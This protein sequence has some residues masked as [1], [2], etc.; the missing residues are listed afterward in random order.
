MNNM[1]VICHSARIGADFHAELKITA[2]SKF[3]IKITFGENEFIGFGVDLIDALRQLRLNFLEPLEISIL[4]N[5]CRRDFVSSRMQRQST[6]GKVG[7][8]LCMGKAS[9]KEDVVLTFDPAP[10]EAV[11]LVAEQDIHYKN[12]LEGLGK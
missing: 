4:L 10:F 7:Y 3:S 9:Q 8:I 6:G 2:D 12:W 5:G 11:A 1:K